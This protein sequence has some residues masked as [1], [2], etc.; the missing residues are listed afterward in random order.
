MSLNNQTSPETHD[1]H[2]HTLRLCPSPWTRLWLQNQQL[3]T[4]N[5]NKK[6]KTQIRRCKYDKVSDYVMMTW[7]TT[8]QGHDDVAEICYSRKGFH[9]RHD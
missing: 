4:F 9:F 1:T 8:P 6:K 5:I 2:K 3:G 7:K